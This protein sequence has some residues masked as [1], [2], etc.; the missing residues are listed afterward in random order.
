MTA[1]VR[2]PREGSSAQIAAITGAPVVLVVN[3]RGMAASAAALVKGFAGFDPHVRLAG[4]IFNNVGG[5]SHAELLRTALAAT[6]PGV[7]VFGCIP[8]DGVTGT[9]LAPPRS[10]NG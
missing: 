10:C 1:S 2:L 5:E 3:A 7:T 8:R 4:V 9:T 6:L